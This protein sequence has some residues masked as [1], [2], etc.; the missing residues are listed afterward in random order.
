M[1]EGGHGGLVSKGRVE[2]LYNGMWGT[3]CDDYWDIKDATVVCRQLGFPGAVAANIS[4]AFGAGKGKIW[5]DNVMCT[6]NESSLTE[7]NRNRWG[8]H[9]CAHGEDAGVICATG[10]TT[11]K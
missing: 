8:T 4:A 5:M 11:S 7:C 9:N 1:N 3:V 2:V 6:G 10:D